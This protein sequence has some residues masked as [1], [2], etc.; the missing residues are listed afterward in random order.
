LLLSAGIVT[1]L[2][3][4]LACAWSVGRDSR[5]ASRSGA[6][7][8]SDQPFASLKSHRADLIPR[9]LNSQALL[10]DQLEISQAARLNTTTKHYAATSTF[11]NPSSSESPS[12]HQKA[13]YHP[14]NPTRLSSAN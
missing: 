2:V 9:T 3:R 6:S 1:L 13:N 5:Q 4:L 11:S 12:G 8:S 10:Q 14:N 7:A